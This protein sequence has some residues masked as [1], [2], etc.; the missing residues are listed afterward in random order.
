MAESYSILYKKIKNYEAKYNC[1]LEN[2]FEDVRENLSYFETE[3]EK[4]M[5]NS[6]EIKPEDYSLAQEQI[7]KGNYGYSEIDYKNT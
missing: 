3:Q 2:T 4:L 6:L 7:R 1:G 5:K